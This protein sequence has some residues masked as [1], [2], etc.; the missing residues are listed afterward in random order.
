M[1]KIHGLQKTVAV[2]LLK[3]LRLL[4]RFTPRNDEQSVFAS[5]RGH[6]RWP[7]Q[8]INVAFE[9][10]QQPRCPHYSHLKGIGMKTNKMLLILVGILIMTAVLSCKRK[11]PEP[12]TESH[13]KP[14]TIHEAAEVGNKAVVEEF[15]LKGIDINMKNRFGMTPLHCAAAYG[16]KEVTELLLANGADVDARN[17]RGGTPLGEAVMGV[18]RNKEVAE[19]LMSKGA[20]VNTKNFDGLTPLHKAVMSVQ[21]DIVKIL[22]INGANPNDRDNDGKTPLDRAISLSEEQFRRG[23]PMAKRKEAFE[24]CVKILR[25]HEAGQNKR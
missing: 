13:V 5:L 10:F 4:R 16:Q 8:S 19:L 1:G 22:L 20:D 25:E 6:R 18:G 17:K 2:G 11:S 7:W 3:K 24:A 12:K 15:L 21:P 9:V 23:S 14:Q